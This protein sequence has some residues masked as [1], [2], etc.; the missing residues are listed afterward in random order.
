M[1]IREV[2]MITG[3]V[4]W[5]CVALFAGI[6][7]VSDQI[8][9]HSRAAD[10]PTAPAVSGLS[11]GRLRHR[12]LRAVGTKTTRPGA[13][14]CGD[15]RR[16]LGLVAPLPD[17]EQPAGHTPVLRSDGQTRS[18]SITKVSRPLGH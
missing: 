1:T 6:V 10:L 12:H 16:A 8:W 2:L 13:P 5:A 14:S 11:R 3:L 15:S 7:V 17:R 4:W 9:R 18:G